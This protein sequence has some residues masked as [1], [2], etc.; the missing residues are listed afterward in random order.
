MQALSGAYIDIID[1]CTKSKAVFR[2]GR[3]SSLTNLNIAFKLSWKPF[4]RQF[5]QQIEDFRIHLKNVEK[6]AGLSHM[7]EAADS[8][9][10]VLANKK[11]MER[12]QKES[13]HRRIIETIPSVNHRAKHKKVRAC[14]F[15]SHSPVQEVE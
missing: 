8:R 9:A 6:E 12:A 11:Q 5:G 10:V 4:E 14:C 7:I 13:K 15:I 1:F 2:H 3:R